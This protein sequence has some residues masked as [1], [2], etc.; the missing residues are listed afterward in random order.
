MDDN[1]EL[2]L[3][4][5]CCTCL[6][7]D[8]KLFQL[9]RVNNG[10]NNLYWLLSSDTEAF[11]EG[12]HTHGA[13]LYICWECNAVMSRM[14][15]FRQQ[16]CMAQ[17]QLT[18]LIEGQNKA[19]KMLSKLT[20]TLKENFD[21]TFTYEDVDNFID[22][23]IGEVKNENNFDFDDIPLS[24]YNN[25]IQDVEK[26]NKKQ[27]TSEKSN[28]KDSIEN[29]PLQNKKQYTIKNEETCK[30]FNVEKDLDR[31]NTDDKKIKKPGS[32]PR[33]NKTMRDKP[34]PFGFLCIEC[35]KY[36]DTKKSRWIHVQRTHREGFECSTCG[37]RFPF[38]NNLTRHQITH[39]S[40][41]PRTE[42]TICHKLVRKDLSRAHSRTHAPRDIYTCVLCVK[43]FASQASYEHHLK[44]TKTHA[45]IDILK[46]KCSVC[47]K[48][49]KSK[50]ELRDHINYQ[51]MG[52]TQHKCPLCGKALATR[53]CVTRHVRR[54]HHGL[55]ENP[56]DK[57]CQQCGKAFRDKKGL[58]EHELIHTGERPLSCEICGCTF[59]Q[60]AS[61]YTH[62]KRIHKI[63]NKRRSI[64][65]M[66]SEIPNT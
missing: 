39:T 24:D 26:Y 4:K 49:Y 51:H 52:K 37:K 34:T 25:Y 54:A 65:L 23:G 16:A 53:R 56:R 36:F 50:G 35:N 43:T 33:R 61:L 30:G 10:V 17:R 58:R 44:Y 5:L 63:C 45:V 15:E 42:C 48:G 22:C 1:S 38:R 31:N 57:M 64:E 14:C 62:R 27:T 40:P 18:C 12:F 11:R 9:C 19:I 6:S 41:Q 21:F 59:R 32:K 66:E 2:L 7:E 20:H 29:E 55:K 28:I 46:Y 3:K 13:S 8:R 47:D 60:H